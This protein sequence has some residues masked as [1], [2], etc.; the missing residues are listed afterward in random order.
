MCHEPNSLP[1]VPHD[2]NV[3]VI[4]E[5]LTLTAAD[6]APFA[7]FAARSPRR[8]GVGVLVFP[9][10]R[11]L[12][13]FYHELAAR[14]AE[15]GHVAAAIDYFGRTA[16]IGER[17][18]DFPFM[19]HVTHLTRAGLQA[20]LAAAVAYLRSPAGGSCRAVVGLGFCFGG[21]QAFL[22]ATYGHG[23][24]GVIGFYG[25]PGPVRNA[26]GPTQLAAAIASPVLA[27]WGGADEGIPP[28]EVAALAAALTAA[29]VEHEMVTYP[30]AP[31]GFFETRQEDFA[32]ASADAW[33]R[34]LDFIERH[35]VQGKRL[36]STSAE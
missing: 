24:A 5:S 36:T 1:A 29:G 13:P 26:P 20:D 4:R 32:G 33:G 14:L 18:A 3:A 2:P 22:S 25:F 16:G 7:G 34:V 15:H 9:D 28:A 19:E 30:G 27:L 23:L 17:G 35:G 6:G 21:R 12:S 8:S 31:H 10:I 11:G